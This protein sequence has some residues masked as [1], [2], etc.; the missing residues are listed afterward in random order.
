MT[1]MIY[2]YCSPASPRARFLDAIRFYRKAVR[3]LFADCLA[4]RY[5][6]LLFATPVRSGSSARQA[7]AA[8]GA[9]GLCAGRDRGDDPRIRASFR[10]RPAVVAPI[11]DLPSRCLTA[12]LP[13]FNR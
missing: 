12:R 1:E 4:R 13:L 2:V 11:L 10:S 8:G 5:P 9:G 7:V 3:S 6:Q